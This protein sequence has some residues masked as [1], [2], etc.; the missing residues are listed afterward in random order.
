[1][2]GQAKQKS[3]R[4]AVV[5]VEAGL[6]MLRYLSSAA[7]PPP[8]LFA[9]VSP[10]CE[11]FVKLIFVP[12]A[13]R[14]A[15]SAPGEYALV[16]AERP[17]SLQL[18]LTTSVG[19]GDDA[20]IQ[21][22]PLSALLAPKP[23]ADEA[24]RS[25]QTARPA[26]R[27]QASPRRRPPAM[28]N[29]STSLVQVARGGADAGAKRDAVA[30]RA[31]PPRNSGAKARDVAASAARPGVPE[32][33][34]NR[35]DQASTLHRD[36]SV[37]SFVCHVARRGDVVGKSGGWVGGPD[38]PAVIEG[39]TLNWAAPAGVALTCQ[40]LV[41]GADGRWSAWTMTGEFAGSRG[42][43]RPVLGL[44]VR[45]AGT[46]ASQYRLSGEAVFL[47]CPVVAE[48]GAQLEFTSYSNADPLVGLKLELIAIAEK[49]NG[50]S[51][52]RV[53]K[54]TGFSKGEGFPGAPA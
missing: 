44:R 22:E 7:A 6:S 37:F 43:G 24:A 39:V 19:G 28:L 36:P 17:G 12:G 54:N 29:S 2:S 16:S 49:A 34:S 5:P 42:R 25:V 20:Q 53:F 50:A 8:R 33:S 45:L 51:R 31:V 1:M 30:P 46:E 41:E 32:A 13:I 23:E 35:V 27:P 9:R 40:A 48:A 11:A 47:G 18:T 4:V 15:L 21:I 38:S 3:E 52:L 10:T 14:E 26:I